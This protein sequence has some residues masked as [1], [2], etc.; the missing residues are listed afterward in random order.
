ME[1][2]YLVSAPVPDGRNGY[3]KDHFSPRKILISKLTNIVTYPTYFTIL[4]TYRFS[5]NSTA[6]KMHSVA[7]NYGARFIILIVSN[8]LAWI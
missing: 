7:R 4:S 2:I 5:R 3:S 6:E 8:I 1:V